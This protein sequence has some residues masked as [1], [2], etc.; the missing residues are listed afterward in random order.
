M[1]SLLRIDVIHRLPHLTVLNWAAGAQAERRYSR[2]LLVAGALLLLFDI[3]SV[4][5]G[6]VGSNV[7]LSSIITFA[8]SSGL[9]LLGA[10][11]LVRHSHLIIATML[12]ICGAIFVI[13]GLLT[14]G[15]L[16]DWSVD[17]EGTFFS[18]LHLSSFGLVVVAEV[19]NA[20]SY[21]PDNFA[22]GFRS[23]AGRNSRWST[24]ISYEWIRQAGSLVV[25]L[26]LYGFILVGLPFTLRL[27]GLPLP[28]DDQEVVIA[29]WVIVSTLAVILLSLASMKIFGLPVGG[30]YLGL[31]GNNATTS[32][33]YRLERWKIRASWAF[34]GVLAGFLFVVVQFG[35][36]WLFTTLSG[37]TGHEG[38]TTST[39]MRTSELRV[40]IGYSLLAVVG[41]GLFEEILARGLIYGTVRRLISTLLE[42]RSLAI[43]AGVLISAAAFA[44]PH[45]YS[46]NALSVSTVV[47]TI[48]FCALYEYTGSL[49]PPIIAHMTHNG[50]PT[51][52]TVLGVL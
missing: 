31:W 39:L 51:I 25:I 8:A 5:N 52:V 3:F 43:G 37:S 1:C 22:F 50:L 48:V 44:I 6:T 42:R 21:V 15:L 14:A 4:I 17:F 49:W 7:L 12:Y 32:I 23:M 35:L 24:N 47:G 26:L 40:V 2:T 29:L 33:S 38:S 13:G 9:L 27:L 36:N 16:L 41:A 30:R 45:G 28:R 11:R 20:V 34:W 46:F 18:I 19:S 10:A